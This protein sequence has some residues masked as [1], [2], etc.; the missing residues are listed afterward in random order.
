MRLA[1]ALLLW[2]IARGASVDGGRL[3]QDIRYLSSPVL[4]GRGTGTAGLDDAAKYIGSQFARAGLKPLNGTSY[5]QTFTV[6]LDNK[7]GPSNAL[8]YGYRNGT[9][10]KPLELQRDYVPLN[11]SGSGHA[12]APVVFAGYGITAIDC[13]YDDY[14]KVDVRGKIVLLL[15][16]EPQE[17]DA[18]S[19]FDGRIYTEHAQLLSKALNAR[20][21]GAVAVLY[22]ND[23]NSHSGPD[24]LE[25][26]S[27]L[28]TPGDPGI[29]FVQIKADVVER[30]FQDAGRNFVEIQQE[31]DKAPAPNSFEIPNLRV[32]LT[33]D[34]QHRAKEVQNVIGFLPGD[35]PEHVIIGAHYDH[36]GTGEQF[37][38]APNMA[39]TVHPGADDNASGTAGMLAVARWFHDNQVVGKRGIVFI[40]FAGEEIG[41]LGSTHY[42][43]NALLPLENAVAM[44]NMDMIGR[45]R[46][47]KVIVGATSSGGGMRGIV[48]EE[49]R[50][51]GL[52][53]DLDEKVVYGSS[54]H[55]TFKAHLVPVLFFFTGLHADYH[56]PSDTWDRIE[57]KS[58][59][60]V[61]NMVARVASHLR[62][63]AEP[64]KFVRATK[65]PQPSVN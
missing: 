33:A 38:L 50:K 44:I 65:T 52:D 16:H 46:E 9:E 57:A 53:L 62:N 60:R 45:P 32:Q 24:A 49:G 35:T 15:R 30:W 18:T 19:I 41:L 12:D 7:L 36:L 39:G 29:P 47:N 14:E 23:T 42:A 34:V 5:F 3:L 6:S 27:H 58:M 20:K 48:Q 10:P 8:S 63:V 26:F 54:D 56:R 51:A 37:S 2:G 64:P 11:F 1:V 59:A 4:G 55:T 61:V 40:A 22:V 21:H 43:N 13:G 17:Y 25:T 31:I 28:A